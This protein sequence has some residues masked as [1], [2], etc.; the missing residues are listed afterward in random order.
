LTVLRCLM[1]TFLN[2]KTG[3]LCPSYRTLQDRTGLCRQSVANGLAR[4]ELTGIVRIVRRI[5]RERVN[6]ISPITGEPESYVGTV[7]TSSLYSL[8]RPGAWSDHLERPAG[9][10]APFPCKRQLDLLQAM[11]L[12]WKTRLS[13]EQKESPRDREK[14]P[15]HVN[16]LAQ[17]IGSACGVDHGR[18]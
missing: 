17:I 18:T 9:R 13:L 8:H 10:R 12:T 6:R 15:P 3:L 1:F 11:A 7:Q 2:S 16:P 4:L 14:G 5:V